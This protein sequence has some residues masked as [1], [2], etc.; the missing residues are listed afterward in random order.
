MR[1][2]IKSLLVVL[3]I[4]V[5]GLLAWRTQL[6]YASTT[7]A[8]PDFH[9]LNRADLSKVASD[10]SLHLEGLGFKA[11]GSPSEM[12]SRAGVVGA[13]TKRGWFVRKESGNRAIWVVVDIDPARVATMVKWENHGTKR[14]RVEAENEALRFAMK[15]DDWFRAR[16]EANQLPAEIGEKRRRWFADELAQNQGGNP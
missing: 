1:P 3:G 6:S 9:T 10:L 16:S 7:F 4:V 8:G 15:L 14:S 11:A 5:I 12:D 2:P 13:N